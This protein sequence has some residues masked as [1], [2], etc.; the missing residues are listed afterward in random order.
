MRALLQRVKEAQVR[1]EG[2]RIGGCGHGLMIL[3]CAMQGDGEEDAAR[4]AA[5]VSKLRIFK[6]EAGKMNRSLLDIEGGALV[7]SQFTLAADTSR[8][9]RPGFSAAA[10]PDV[11]ERLYELFAKD[12]AALGVPVE[13]GKFGADM[14]VSLV[15]DGPVTIWVES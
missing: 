9:N 7:V 13:T 5:K 10:A 4:L 3:V 12:L 1:V 2:E 15:N 6:D 14:Q 11:G 8:G